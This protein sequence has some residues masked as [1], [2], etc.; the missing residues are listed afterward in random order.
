MLASGAAVDPAGGDPVVTANINH[1]KGFAF[2]EFRRIEDA[3]SSLMFDGVVFEGSNVVVKRP[4][5]Y[6][7]SRNPLR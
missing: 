2:V 6:D 1:E 7:P 5:D 3:E 4:K